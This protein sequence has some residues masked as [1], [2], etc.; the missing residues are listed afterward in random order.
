MSMNTAPAPRVEPAKADSARSEDAATADMAQPVRAPQTTAAPRVEPATMLDPKQQQSQQQPQTSNVSVS[1]LR[2]QGGA[3]LECHAAVLR[4]ASKKNFMQR[5][6]PCIYDE[7]DFIAFGEV[8]KYCLIKAGTCFVF[9]QIS[10]PKPL[11][12][13]PL[14]DGT[15]VAFQEDPH[16]PDAGSMTINPLPNTNKQPEH[17]VT[18]SLKYRKNNKQAYQFTFDTQDVDKSVPQQFLDLVVGKKKADAATK[19][20]AAVT[21]SVAVAGHVAASRIQHQPDI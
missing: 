17:L 14:D 8:K 11:Y 20:T 15:F 21:A 6:L 18:I 4:G 2:G 10:D 7:R 9:G 13:I 3:D 5:W 1:V 19:G 12:A 16:K